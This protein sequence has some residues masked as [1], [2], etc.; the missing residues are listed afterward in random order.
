MSKQPRAI[1]YPDNKNR[2]D[3]AL[4]LAAHTTAIQ[5]TAIEAK[6]AID[7]IDARI[8]PTMNKLLAHH[9]LKTW[10]QLFERVMSALTP[11]DKE[12]YRKLVQGFKDVDENIS[13]SLTIM[14]GILFSTA[15][16]GK[17]IDIA[18]FLFSGHVI[19]TFRG[20][21]KAFYLMLTKGIDAGLK[22]YQAAAKAAD[23]AIDVLKNASKIGKWAK[24]AS[25]V[26][27]I[28]AVIGVIADAFILAMAYFE[29]KKQRDELRA[30]IN[31]LYVRRLISKYYTLM[32]DTLKSNTTTFEMYIN[33]WDIYPDPTDMQQEMLDMLMTTNINTISK[34]FA[35]YDAKYCYDLCKAL[36]TNSWTNEDPS[37]A[38]A[39]K[40]ADEDIG[41]STSLSSLAD[42]MDDKHIPES[43]IELDIVMNTTFPG[44]SHELNRMAHGRLDKHNELSLTRRRARLEH[45]EK[46]CHH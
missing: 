1:F 8:I 21:A 42:A 23:S 32:C 15:A 19:S 38:N 37:E 5:Q 30:A 12:A 39:I 18:F 24:N 43:A 16:L 44:A 34:N 28:V 41:G 13:D 45:V 33:F 29:E 17:A 27:K 3:R 9:G 40:Q 10:D 36:D 22:A 35:D 4:E 46:H 20:Y 26:L 11:E 14:S 2:G 31:E 25:R 6:D 7:K